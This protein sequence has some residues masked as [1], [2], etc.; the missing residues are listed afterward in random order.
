[1][2][3]MNNGLKAIIVVFSEALW[4]YYFII[5]FTSVEWDGFV[6]F[7]TFWWGVA[8]ISGYVVNAL[9]F[10][11]KIMIRIITNLILAGIVLFKNWEIS[12]PEGSL[13]FGIAV[14]IAVVA[15]WMRSAHFST[16]K[17]KRQDLMRCFEGNIVLYLVFAFVY[18]KK[19]WGADNLHLVFL[20]AI[21]MSLVGMILSLQTHADGKGEEVT[22]IRKVGKSSSLTG[23]L[24]ALFFSIPILSLSLLLPGM[25]RMVKAFFLTL[26]DGVKWIGSILAQCL[27]WFANLFP[28]TPNGE[29]KGIESG[30]SA[31]APNGSEEM[32]ST[33][34]IV[35]L[36][37]G[38]AF[39]LFS[40]A[41]M[42]VI[43]VLKNRP[44]SVGGVRPK[45][46]EVSK[47][48]WWNYFINKISAIL[49]LLKMSW[50]RRFPHYY[51][52]SV[53]WYFYQLQKWGKKNGILIENSETS[54][55]YIQRIGK[56]IPPE[57]EQHLYR[58]ETYSI[59]E[60]LKVLNKDYQAAYYGGIPSSSNEQ[61]RMLIKLLL[62]VR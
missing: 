61:Y 57:K 3:Q 47:E 13:T 36:L 34:P 2:E 23:L 1:M 39:I 10:K 37:A 30:G 17:P 40:V 32:V 41:I 42:V 38:M 53:Y 60:L 26:W 50:R 48:P 6:S 28:D 15:I 29:L 27:L 9:L 43:R 33:F 18:M 20:T 56:A 49:L 51:Q 44:S 12:V 14:T 5:L 46:I 24:T 54:Q 21:G 58:G 25:N 16:A 62:S 8:G 35:W 4:M 55:E 11:N 52:D 59:E 31:G 22:E 19:E 45:R 7:N